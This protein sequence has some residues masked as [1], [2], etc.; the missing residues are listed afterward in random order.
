MHQEYCWLLPELL[1]DESNALAAVT[2]LECHRDLPWHDYL[3]VIQSLAG[4]YLQIIG[5]PA[6]VP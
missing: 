6:D 2:Q 1:R 4:L 3:F 5:A